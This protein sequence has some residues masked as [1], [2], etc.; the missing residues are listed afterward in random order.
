VRLV[1]L[2]NPM[3]QERAEFRAWSLA[4]DFDEFAAD[5]HGLNPN[6]AMI[7]NPTMNQE[8]KSD[9]YYGVRPE[10]LLATADAIWTEEP[11]VPQWI[12]AGRL[13]SQI[14]SYKA[15]RDGHPSL[16]L[17]GSGWVSSIQ[18]GTAPCAVAESFAYDDTNL[19]LITGRDVGTIRRRCCGNM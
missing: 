8:S 2:H 14:R 13:V 17:A 15:A 12:E 1:E 16:P 4:R 18:E 6:V 10:E 11:N 19:G 7:A 9:L 3:M 5:I